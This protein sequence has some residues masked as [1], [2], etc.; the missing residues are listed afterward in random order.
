MTVSLVLTASILIS[1][2]HVSPFLSASVS[3]RAALGDCQDPAATTGR[4]A[5]AT[6]G[7]PLSRPL[8]RPHGD[9]EG[10]GEGEG[11]GRA[12]APRVA[13]AAEE[14]AGCGGF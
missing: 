3:L 8:G 7:R 10:D 12:T 13:A 1:I 4:S 11:V 9:G 5:A 2:S 6:R 14:E